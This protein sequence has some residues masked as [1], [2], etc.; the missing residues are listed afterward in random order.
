MKNSNFSARL[1]KTAKLKKQTQTVDPKFSLRCTKQLNIF[2]TLERLDHYSF[3]LS[4]SIQRKTTA[5]SGYLQ[6]LRHTKFK[7]QHGYYELIL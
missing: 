1:A 4:L 5:F 6:V 2:L 3:N 7:T